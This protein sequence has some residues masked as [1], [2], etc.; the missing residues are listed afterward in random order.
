MNAAHLHLI[1]NHAPLFLLLFGTA[2][3]TWNVARPK[4]EILILAI[5]LFMGAGVAS[6]VSSKTGEEAEEIV[7]HL[8]DVTDGSIHEHE[9]AA[10]WAQAI[11][12][13]VAALG[14]GLLVVNKYKPEREKAMGSVVLL[15]AVLGI[16][17]MAKTSYLGGMIRHF[18]IRDG[19]DPKKDLI[20]EEGDQMGD[21]DIGPPEAFD[22]GEGAEDDLPE[23]ESGASGKSVPE[24]H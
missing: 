2:M 8:P 14:M 18:E 22:E 23:T 11:T 3:L 24:A 20:E 21:Y 4:K 12:L 5:A 9:E 10:E 19:F 17:A 6:L 16:A 13:F 7:E 15:V 1:V